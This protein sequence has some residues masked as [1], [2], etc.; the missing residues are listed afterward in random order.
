VTDACVHLNGATWCYMHERPLLAC[1]TTPEGIVSIPPQ[2]GAAKAVEFAAALRAADRLRAATGLP[3]GLCV[4]GVPEP[5]A[6]RSGPAPTVSDPASGGLSWSF[7]A[8]LLSQL[9]EARRAL[10][11]AENAVQV[12]GPVPSE[13]E[14]LLELARDELDLYRTLHDRQA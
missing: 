5:S 12:G 9:Q 10:V 1:P 8:G 4:P 14:G 11:Q 13:I 7:R 6:A 2:L 3:W